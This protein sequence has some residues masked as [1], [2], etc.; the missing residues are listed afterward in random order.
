MPLCTKYR[1]SLDA[2][3]TRRPNTNKPQEEKV[4]EPIW[5]L[6]ITD[7]AEA[8]D[9]STLPSSERAV[10]TASGRSD[11]DDASA[12]AAAAASV[13]STAAVNPLP[14]TEHAIPPITG[15]NFTAPSDER[16]KRAVPT[17]VGGLGSATPSML[18]FTELS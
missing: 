17:V 1:S 7:K 3:E 10:P 8:H 12:P 4:D 15:I 14:G 6:Q 5:S 13:T 16:E 18:A 11:T 9:L 2:R